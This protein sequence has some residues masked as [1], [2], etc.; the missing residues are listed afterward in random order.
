MSIRKC[1]F[2]IIAFI[3]LLS[4]ASC[5]SSNDQRI[6]LNRPTGLS[7]SVP[8]Y[9]HGATIRWHAVPYATGYIIYVDD[10]IYL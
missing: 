7:C 2:I 5:N 3:M 10:F 8:T 6:V 4:F 1:W 9:D